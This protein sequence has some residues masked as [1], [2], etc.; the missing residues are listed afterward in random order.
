LLTEC[1]TSTFRQKLDEK[2][3]N[4]WTSQLVQGVWSS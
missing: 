4:G 3:S 2:F 1:Y